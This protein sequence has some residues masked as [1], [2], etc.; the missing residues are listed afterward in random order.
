MRV[1]RRVLLLAALWLVFAVASVGVGF[2]AAG[3]I[4]GP[5]A[6]VAGPRA[7][8]ATTPATANGPSATA[9]AADPPPSGATRGITTAGGYVSGVCEAGLIRL[10][11][12]PEPGWELVELSNSDAEDDPDGLRGGDVEFE[13]AGPGTGTVSVEAWCSGGI[14]R[15]VVE[16]DQ[17]DEFDEDD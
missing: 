7:A 15:F 16:A 17:D 1:M 3:L 8:A 13:Q 12:S 6:T 2:T 11:A 9:S 5:L 14:P 4:E 10:S